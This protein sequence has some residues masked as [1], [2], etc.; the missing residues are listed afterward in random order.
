[1][2]SRDSATTPANDATSTDTFKKRTD[3]QANRF[4]DLRGVKCPI[5]FAQTKIQL[6]GMTPGE[7]L[8]IFLDDG[9]PVENV[10]GSVKLEG[11]HVLRQEKMGEYWSVLI[12]KM[13]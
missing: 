7:I 6:A 9:D 10:P 3:R 12:E 4:K 5:N 2:A 1:M 13:S 8:E 11:H